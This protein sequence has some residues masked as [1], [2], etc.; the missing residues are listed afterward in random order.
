MHI[1]NATVQDN[2]E[3][4]CLYFVDKNSVS[5]VM[6]TCNKA[7]KTLTTT[8]ESRTAHAAL[9]ISLPLNFNP[10]LLSL[11]AIT[12]PSFHFLLWEC[13]CLDKITCLF[14]SFLS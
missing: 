10:T 9:H 11:N 4:K 8:L 14:C 13:T 2:L 12:P 5:I 3:F 6:S 1:F 7:Y